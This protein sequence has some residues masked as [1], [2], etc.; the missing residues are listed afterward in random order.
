MI[1][2]KVDKA[3]TVV[4]VVCIF[5]LIYL[6]ATM[7]PNKPT[8]SISED[9]LPILTEKAFWDGYK[10]GLLRQKEDSVWGSVSKEYKGIFKQY[11]KE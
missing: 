7:K 2:D 5:M 1:Q 6:S 10:A 8:I 3:L 9:D 11:V 4:V